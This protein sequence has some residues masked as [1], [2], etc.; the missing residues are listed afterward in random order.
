M[1]SIPTFID[2]NHTMLNLK[3]LYDHIFSWKGRHLSY[4]FIY[5][6]LTTLAIYFP[7]LIGIRPYIVFQIGF[8]FIS[9][10]MHNLLSRSLLWDYLLFFEFHF[11]KLFIIRE[12]AL[13]RQVHFVF[14]FILIVLLSRIAG[15]KGANHGFSWRRSLSW[16]FLLTFLRLDLE[17]Q[18]LAG[19]KGMSHNFLNTG[20]VIFVIH[21]N[22]LQKMK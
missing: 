9:A 6:I 19:E 11:E 8:M 4:S 5:G 10:G 15:L 20:P 2:L 13:Q 1:T 21:E 14:I 16:Q 17:R 18:W 22:L 7:I 3:R 12:S